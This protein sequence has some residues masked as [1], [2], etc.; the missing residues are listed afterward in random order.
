M[1]SISENTL[2]PSTNTANMTTYVTNQCLVCPVQTELSKEA[3]INIQAFILERVHAKDYQGV[4]IDLSGV[5]VIDSVLWKVFSNTCV[6]VNMLGFQTV[7]TGLNP[8]VVAAIMDINVDL[9]KII[10]AMSIQDALDIL[11]VKS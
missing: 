8:G 6:M 10:T 3:A 11:A 9:T 5:Q 2:V 1:S 4:I 7:I